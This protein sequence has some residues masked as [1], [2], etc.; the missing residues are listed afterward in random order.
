MPQTMVWYNRKRSV[1]GASTGGG[2]DTQSTNGIVHG[3]AYAVI[4]VQQV[5]NFKMIKLRNPW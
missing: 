4:D 3:H 2:D 1:I 5:D